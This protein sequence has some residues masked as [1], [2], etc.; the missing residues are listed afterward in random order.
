LQEITTAI[1]VKVDISA[2]KGLIKPKK[3]FGNGFGVADISD[4]DSPILVKYSSQTYYDNFEDPTSKLSDVYQAAL[5]EA[6][7]KAQADAKAKLAIDAKGAIRKEVQRLEGLMNSYHDT[8]RSDYKA[9]QKSDIDYIN[10]SAQLATL[11]KALENRDQRSE[12]SKQ[13]ELAGAEFDRLL[14]VLSFKSTNDAYDYLTGTL[15]E[16]PEKGVSKDE[17]AKARIAEINK[18]YSSFRD[19]TLEKQYNAEFDASVASQK[20]EAE[21]L[22]KDLDSKDL[23]YKAV[24]DS[25][26]AVAS[27][28]L[29][30]LNRNF[31]TL[32]KDFESNL[33]SEISQAGAISKMSVEDFDDYRVSLGEKS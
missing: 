18:Q 15:K 24:H 25:K 27:R 9:Y 7:V 8:L 19:G 29:E 28:N 16:T 11:K 3:N 22:R 33:N 2:A 13:M 6:Y 31:S 26:V 20:S 12:V 4:V 17:F 1:K 5:K 30:E 21:R 14:P 10:W 23:A 32:M